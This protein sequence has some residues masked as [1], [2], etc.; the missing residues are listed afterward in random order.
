M[1]QVLYAPE[2]V[3]TTELREAVVLILRYDPNV[4]A[5]GVR[6]NQLTNRPAAEVVAPDWQD[7]INDPGVVFDGGPTQHD[8]YIALGRV[9][10]D[11]ATPVRFTRVVGDIGVIRMSAP[12]STVQDTLSDLRIFSG[13]FGWGPGELEADLAERVLVPTDASPEEAFTSRPSGLWH[14]LRHPERGEG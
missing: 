13:Y 9:H 14:R 7:L 4:G 6:L 3:D 1:G 5:F 2:N 8:G 10:L 11:K 12:V